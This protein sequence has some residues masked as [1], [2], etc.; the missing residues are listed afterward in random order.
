MH[1]NN[2]KQNKTWVLGPMGWIRCIHCGKFGHDF[3]ARTI[4]SI[5]PF[6]LFLHR[7]SCSNEMVPNAP[8]H[9]ERIKWWVWGVMGWIGCVCCENIWH[10][11][12]A[13][14]F[15]LIA[16][17]QPILHWVYSRNKTNPNAPK[18]YK[19]KQ[20]MSF[21]A[22]GVDRVHSLRQIRTRLRGTNYCINCTISA[23]FAPSFMQ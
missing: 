6:Q 5:A 9:Y 22:N 18:H 21:G 3:V 23:R 13:Q 12:V 7:V 1:P 11:F 17:V 20:N 16:P 8:K 19:T 4:A 10:N 2:T 14:T 15:A